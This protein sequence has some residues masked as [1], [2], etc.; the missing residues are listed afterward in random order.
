[1]AKMTALLRVDVSN[2]NAVVLAES[3]PKT[4]GAASSERPTFDGMFQ[5]WLGDGWT[6]AAMT[7]MDG[8]LFVAV[9]RG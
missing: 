4:P 2:N 6:I 1:M 8:Y 5:N 7:S 9:E 3:R